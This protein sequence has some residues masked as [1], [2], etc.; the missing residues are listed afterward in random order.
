M[1]MKR[2]AI[3]ATELTLCVHGGIGK[4][5]TSGPP[6]GF[7][8]TKHDAKMI[9]TRPFCMGGYDVSHNRGVKQHLPPDGAEGHLVWLI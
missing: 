3:R 7:K 5:T 2:A 6:L 9:G 1:W 4:G 8:N